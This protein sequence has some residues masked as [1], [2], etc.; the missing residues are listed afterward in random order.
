MIS[1]KK[2]VNSKSPSYIDHSHAL[3]IEIMIKLSSYLML[4]LRKIVALLKPIK[5]NIY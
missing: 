1:L 3:K 4:I 5:S 2:Q